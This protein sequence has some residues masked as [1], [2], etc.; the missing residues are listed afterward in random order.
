ME[1]LDFN[2]WSHEVQQRLELQAARLNEVS[3]P[4][5]KPQVTP[6]QA[7]HLASLLRRC[8]RTNPWGHPTAEC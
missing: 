8:P 6:T 2:R 4:L 7:Y 3:Q 5:P 1:W